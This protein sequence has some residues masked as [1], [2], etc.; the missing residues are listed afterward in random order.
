MN[1]YL[2]A[3]PLETAGA[4]FLQSPS[5]M[6]LVFLL[7]VL[8]FL[9]LVALIYRRYVRSHY[10]IPVKYQQRILLVTVPKEAAGAKDQAVTVEKTKE[11]IAAAESLW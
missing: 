3:S 2:P 1:N 9:F 11:L 6:V 5:A 4:N 8:V 7:G 10:K